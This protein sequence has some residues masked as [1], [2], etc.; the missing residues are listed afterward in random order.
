VSILRKLFV[1]LLDTNEINAI[2]IT[3]LE[4][5]VDNN[6]A[7]RGEV[8]GR[9]NNYT[10][11]PSSAQA[12]RQ[13]ANTNAFRGEVM[14]RTNNYIAEPSS[15]PARVPYCHLQRKVSPLGEGK[16]MLYSEVVEGKTI[17]K[18]YKLTVTSIGNQTADKIKEMLKSNINPT[19]IKMGIGLLE[20]LRDGSVQIKTESIPEAET[21]TNNIKDKLGDKMETNI[22]RPR[23]TRLKIHN[24]PEDISTDKTEDAVIAQN[25]YLSIE[26]LEISPKFN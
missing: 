5:Q 20:T 6:N 24:I 16:V 11:E 10:A 19:E 2:K 26:K 22:Q 8:T 25:S 15:A 18:M 4:R 9:T 1:K 3:E 7:F 12:E 21:L 17:L 14:G 13:I 23:K